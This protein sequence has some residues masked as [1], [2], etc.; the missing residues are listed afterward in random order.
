MENFK[1][2]AKADEDLLTISAL[3]ITEKITNEHGYRWKK[4][5]PKIEVIGTYLHHKTGG[6]TRV[7]VI[8]NC[9][10]WADGGLHQH[11]PK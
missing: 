7:K 3:T 1:I 9:Q 10:N 8:G 5:T 2:E 11:L 6:I 4:K